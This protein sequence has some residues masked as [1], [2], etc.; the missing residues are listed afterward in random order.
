MQEAIGASITQVRDEMVGE[1]RPLGDHWQECDCG[2]Q[3]WQDCTYGRAD[4][5]LA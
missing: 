2:Y 5:R 3:D 1:V 4:G